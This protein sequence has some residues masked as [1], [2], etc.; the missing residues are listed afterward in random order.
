MNVGTLQDGARG[1][2]FNGPLSAENART[3]AQ[4]VFPEGHARAGERSCEFVARYVRRHQMHSYDLTS[5]EVLGIVEA[6]LGLTFVQHVAKEGWMPTPN[7]GALFG[8]TA[9]REA[10]IVGIPSG[11]TGWCD[12][13][14]VHPTA[15]HADTIGYLVNWYEAVC[16]DYEAGLYVGDSCGLTPRE[17]YN[18]PFQHYWGAYNLNKDQ[19]PAV[20]GL[21]MRQHVAHP[22]DFIPG[23]DNQNMDIDVIHADALGG[24][25]TL[26]LP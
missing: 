15:K 5:G 21:Q 16:V 6:G 1:Y 17:L 2:D 3:L 20:R 7:D 25:P 14:G 26:L 24:T 19:E 13:E 23:F 12:L 8:S 9:A 11:V 18:L 4:R 22:S 10:H